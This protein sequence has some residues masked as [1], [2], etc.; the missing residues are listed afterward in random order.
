MKK[1]AYSLLVTIIVLFLLA[2]AALF[3]RYNT[4]VRIASVNKQVKGTGTTA[5]TNSSVNSNNTVKIIFSDKFFVSG[6]TSAK[7]AF[8]ALVNVAQ[9]N[10]ISIKTKDYDFGKMVESIKDTVNTKESFWMYQV[11][12][13]P[14]DKAADQYQIK[15][16]DEVVWE[17]K[18]ITQ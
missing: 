14:G 12:G 11:N 3:L 9:Q 10:N 8:E 4:S 5:S 1:R 18:K 13:K 15:P 7:T 17:Y 16:G 6:S 2:G